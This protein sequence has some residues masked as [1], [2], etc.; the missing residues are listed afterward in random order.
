MKCRRRTVVRAHY[1]AFADWLQRT[2]LGEDRPEARGGGARFPPCRHHLCRLRRGRRHRAADP[3]RH[4]PAHHP[5]RRMAHARARAQAARAR[6][7]PVP[8]RHLSRSRHPQ[9]RRDSGGAR[10]RQHAVPARDAGHGRAGRHLRAHR[11]RRRGA[12]GRGRIL[13]ARRQPARAVR[14][15]VH[16]REPQDD[17]AAVSRAVRDAADP[18]GRAL[19]RPAAGE[20]ARRRA[21]GR[22]AAR[23]R[24]AHA[25]VPTTRRTSSTR[26]WR[27]RWASSWSR[28]RISSSRTTRCTCAPRAVRS[29]ST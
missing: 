25:R 7:Q 6:A 26:S 18:A 24:R 4:R 3:V 9:G 13:R 28:A 29:A 8:A 17:D 15:L 23:G 21:G 16:A 1:Q 10:A 22:R 14:R 27:S 2:P 19:S 5:R 11:R 20:P 12:R